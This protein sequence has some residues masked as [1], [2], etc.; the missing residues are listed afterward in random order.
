VERVT[1]RELN[2]AAHLAAW[3]IGLAL[4][5]GGPTQAGADA[6]PTRIVSLNLCTDQLVMLLAEPERIAA[7]SHLARDPQLSVLADDAQRL[8]V[9]YGQA[10]EVFLLKPDLV[11]AGSFNIN[12]SVD[13]LRRL[14]VRVEELPSAN[15]FDE[16]RMSVRR[17]GKLLGSEANAERLVA[18][19]DARLAA[20]DR[21]TV[22][23]SQLAALY[24]AN[25]YTSG[26]GT[27]AAE[28]V[29]R[30]GFK[31]L[32]SELGLEGVAELP[33]ETLV[34]RRPDLVV[35]GLAYQAPALAQEIFEH[36]ALAYLQ[37]RSQKVAIPEN[38]WICGTPFTARAVEA[39]ADVGKALPSKTAAALGRSGATAADPPMARK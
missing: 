19:F 4:A 10:E 22:S 11:V 34:M 23:R 18:E 15:S 29:Q 2:S 38:L 3:L 26:A 39:L 5:W 36:P 33:L 6:R 9:N 32:G 17:M 20:V 8:P 14:G 31:N 7:I 12:A 37:Q 30:A 28:V 25:S 21:S 35:T 1:S 24:Y 16:I 13:I 27:L